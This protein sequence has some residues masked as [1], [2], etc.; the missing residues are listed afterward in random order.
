MNFVISAFFPGDECFLTLGKQ[1]NKQINKKCHHNWYSCWEAPIKRS[2]SK[3]KGWRDTENKLLLIPPRKF[4]KFK[5][6]NKA[7]TI[8]H[9]LWTWK[10]HLF[11]YLFFKLKTEQTF[12]FFFLNEWKVIWHIQYE[13]SEWF[14]WLANYRLVW[15]LKTSRGFYLGDPQWLWEYEQ[16]MRSGRKCFLQNLK[17]NLPRLWLQLIITVW[18]RKV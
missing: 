9:L 7:E 11:I 17:E 13:V 16:V 12:F 3:D 6:V 2:N 4:L 14:T 10:L 5:I 15:R 18:N 1:I 8:W